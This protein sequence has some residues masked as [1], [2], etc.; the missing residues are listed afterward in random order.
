MGLVSAMYS[1][2][3]G[4]TTNS[5]NLNVISNNIANVNTVGFKSGA[6]VFQDVLSTVLHNGST[7]MQFGHG[8]KIG[9]VSTSYAQGSFEATTSATDLAIDGN[10]FFV[11]NNGAGNFYTRAGQ[12]RIGSQGT[13]VNPQGYTLQ[14]YK[15]TNGVV[16]NAVQNVDLAGIQSS[17][18]ATTS[19]TAGVNLNAAASAA[20]TFTTPVT[21]Y[22][23][24]GDEVILTITFTKISGLNS[25]SFTPTTSIG[26]VDVNGAASGTVS[27]DTSGQLSSIN[28]VAIGAGATA[29]VFNFTFP[30][31][32]IAPPASNQAVTW[33]LLNTA[34]TAS[35]GKLTGYAAQSNNNSLVQDGFATGVLTGLAVSSDGRISGVFDNGQTDELYQI[36][37]A[38]FLNPTGL[39]KVGSNLYTASYQSGSATLGTA[40]SGGFGSVLG[41]TLELANVDIATEFVKMITTQQAYQASA[42]TITTAN[43]L[44]TEAINLKR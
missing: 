34:G 18:Q 42:R 20:T 9:G 3:S 30:G 22:N 19:F 38:N 41:D 2:V 40:R 33:S 16:G 17:P 32:A 25:W 35:N 10:G 26:T 29:P 31:S 5:Q 27:F 44:M 36:V 39:N 14:G 1:G 21:M 6:A 8:A 15:I 4:I 7:T 28:G 24:V 23:S 11:V 43:D 37:L 12:F 13:L